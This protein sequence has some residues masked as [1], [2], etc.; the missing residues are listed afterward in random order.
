MSDVKKIPF[1]GYYYSSKDV[2]KYAEFISLPSS[3]SSLLTSYQPTLYGD[4]LYFLYKNDNIKRF[5]IYPKTSSEYKTRK[6]NFFFHPINGSCEFENQVLVIGDIVSK[7]A[8]FE[9]YH[10]TSHFEY[11]I[12][13]P[14]KSSKGYYTGIYITC[15][16]KKRPLSVSFHSHVSVGGS[17]RYLSTCI[18]KFK[19]RK[20]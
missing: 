13:K 14:T 9:I 4:L 8:K 3:M 17:I 15:E 7:I 16:E 10:Q 11:I 2:G 6:R 20:E 18:F 19:L 1:Y 5:Y 12:I